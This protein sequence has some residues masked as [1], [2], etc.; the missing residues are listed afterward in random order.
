M[1]SEVTLDDAIEALRNKDKPRAREILDA[2]IQ[3]DPQ[4][5]MAWLYMALVAKN[6]EQALTCLERATQIN[7]QNDK[8]WEWIEKL[9]SQS[10]G[11]PRPKATVRKGKPNPLL[12]ALI[13]V[14]ALLVIVVLA[15]IGLF[16]SGYFNGGSSMAA[17]P[18]SATL[19]ASKSDISPQASATP[20]RN[21]PP[22]WTPVARLSPPPDEAMITYLKAF[23]PLANE[24][25]ALF[26][27]TNESYDEYN[28]REYVDKIKLFREQLDKLVVPD[29]AKPMHSSFDLVVLSIAQK[30]LSYQGAE[31]YPSQY[32]MYFAA[33]R[34]YSDNALAY[35]FG[36]YLPA[37]NHLLQ[38]IGLT[39][40]EIGFAE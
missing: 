29:K 6:R 11:Q 3:R 2:V 34:Q 36:S 30:H 15:I 35:Y 37:R 4:N 14:S 5:D 8:A 23:A 12:L 18:S 1:E 40:T 13:G 25:W 38:E 19:S 32:E 27:T 24:I 33:A 28:P 20:T 7:P 10:T 22:T 26:F 31:L 16:A 17:I 21:V 9:K 39:A